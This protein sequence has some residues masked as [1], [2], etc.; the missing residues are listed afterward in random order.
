MEPGRRSVEFSVLARTAISAPSVARRT[1]RAFP[2]P[3]LAPV[4][5]A[6]RPCR[7]GW[8]GSL[9]GRQRL[10]GGGFGDG[11]VNGQEFVDAGHAEQPHDAGIGARQPEFASGF[12]R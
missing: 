11:G 1:A 3:R 7:S 8:S 12:L 2:M 9:I 4:M 6:T 5:R 10:A